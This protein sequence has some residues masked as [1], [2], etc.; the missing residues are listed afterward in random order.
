MLFHGLF[1]APFGADD[2]PYLGQCVLAVVSCLALVLAPIIQ[3]FRAHL[4]LVYPAH[5]YCA[6]LDPLTLEIFQIVVH[7]PIAGLYNVHVLQIRTILI[8]FL[9][10]RPSNFPQLFRVARAGVDHVHEVPARALPPLAAVHYLLAYVTGP[11]AQ[12]GR[13]RVGGADTRVGIPGK[14][15]TLVSVLAGGTDAK[16]QEHHQ[17]SAN[18]RSY[19]TAS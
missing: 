14:T 17:K 12:G 16:E 9:F 10:G 2:P 7:D 11:L 15:V 19:D 1:L 13:S 4:L 3:R 5:E 8:T 18:D 6:M